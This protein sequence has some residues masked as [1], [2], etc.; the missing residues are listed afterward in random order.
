VLPVPLSRML[1]AYT[2]I[3]E[4][5]P[6]IGTENLIPVTNPIER[7]NKEVKRRADVVGIFPNEASIMRLIGAVL[8]EQNDEWQTS[9]RYMMVEAF[10][11][12]DKEE[13][14]PILSITT[15]AA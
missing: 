8:F 13:I 6:N 5:T 9:S 10:A 11:Q 3:K 1:A 2:L 7:L 14:D 12:I 4:S 15:K